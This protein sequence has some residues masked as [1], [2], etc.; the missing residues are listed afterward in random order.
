MPASD[1]LIVICYDIASDATRRKMASRLERVGVRV[2]K[3]VFETRMR[4]RR[5]QGLGEKLA[6]LLGP[7]DSL[8]LYTVGRG[9]HAMSRAWGATPM[10]GAEDFWVV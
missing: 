6:R 4:A 9:G 10:A 3:S 7:E 5:A 2:Q 1:Q 8:R